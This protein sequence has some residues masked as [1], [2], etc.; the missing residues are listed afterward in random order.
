MVYSLIG[1]FLSGAPVS[2]IAGYLVGGVHGYGES[3]S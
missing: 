1:I 2:G 3:Q